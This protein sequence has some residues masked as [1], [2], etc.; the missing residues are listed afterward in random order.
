M[1][2]SAGGDISKLFVGNGATAVTMRI[3][4]LPGPCDTRSVDATVSWGAGRGQYRARA[5]CYAGTDWARSLEFLPKGDV[6]HPVPVSCPKFAFTYNATGRVFTVVMPRSCLPKAPGAVRG[7]SE[8]TVYGSAS[9]GTA[10]PTRLL[11]RG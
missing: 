6:Q 8:A 2:G 9:Y 1:P 5:A 3:Y 11:P 4:G 10:G 7:S